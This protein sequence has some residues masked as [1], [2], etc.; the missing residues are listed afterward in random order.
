M[1]TGEDVDDYLLLQTA[2]RRTGRPAAFAEAYDWAEVDT[3]E[4]GLHWPLG[5]RILPP[6]PETKEL[7][8]EVE[9]LLKRAAR[10][11]LSGKVSPK[12]V[13]MV[14]WDL[15]KLRR[16]LNERADA[17][18]VSGATVDEAE[19]FLDQLEDFVEGL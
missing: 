10:Q 8:S 16:L 17:M 15:G 7:R 5:L 12:L 18:P 6:G 19:W 11:A 14:K 4:G 13:L 1:S 3:D 9:S 2:I